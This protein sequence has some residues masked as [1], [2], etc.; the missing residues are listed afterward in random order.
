VFSETVSGV[1]L[2]KILASPIGQ[3]YQKQYGEVPQPT[4]VDECRRMVRQ[5]DSA[6]D[7][8]KGVNRRAL[9][10]DEQKHII[11]ERILTKVG[12]Q[13][14][15]ERYSMIID[16]QKGLTSLF[17]LFE[18]QRLILAAFARVEAERYDAGHPDGILANILKG[19]Q[20]GASTLCQSILAH[21][22][23]TRTYRNAL[24]AS[25]VPENSGSTGLFGKLELTVEHLPFW[26][27]PPER[28]HTKNQ[29]IVWQNHSSVV[30][31]SGKSMKG[32]LQD[33]GGSKGQMGRSKTY[34]AAHLS[35]LST[36]ENA[37]QV[38]DA[39]M[40]A[41][42]QTPSTFL[43]KE[44]TAKG[45]FNWWHKEWLAT[46]KGLG[47]SF[48]IFIPWYAEKTKYSV[49]PPASWDP[50]DFVLD[51][52]LRVEQ[53]SHRWMRR[54]YRLTKGQIYWYYLNRQAAEEKDTLFKFLEEYPAEPE[55]AFQYSGRSIFKPAE[56][57]RMRR[58][59]KPAKQIY[60][61]LP[62]SLIAAFRDSKHSERALAEAALEY[63]KQ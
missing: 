44:S 43:V 3:A 6:W 45:R 17:P 50:P 52:A 56:V 31:E 46:A 54:T 39:L 37:G 55:E 59:A 57:D 33:E 16:P 48:N 2:E 47:R 9:T 15:A 5:L 62:N 20:L 25:D 1:A 30:V 29:H 58:L 27:A 8:V 18:S 61:V 32:A 21:G 26:L 53:H 28:F 41:I 35:E 13:Y 19:R 11:T 51:Y 60:R 14:W 40:P 38:D 22:C 63:E 34:G 36:W 23:T 7:P 4:P 12:Y 10:R 49:P 24:I 42:P